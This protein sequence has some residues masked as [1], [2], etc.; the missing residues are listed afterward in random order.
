MEE[1]QKKNLRFKELIFL[2]TV[3]PLE[4]QNEVQTTLEE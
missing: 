4:T 3:S 2:D 1:P